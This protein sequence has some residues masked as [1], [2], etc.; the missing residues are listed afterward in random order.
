MSDAMSHYRIAD[1][2]LFRCDKSVLSH[3]KED[4]HQFLA[5]NEARL[6][7]FFCRNHG[8]IVSR[9]QIQNFVWKDNGFQVEDSNL[10]QAIFSLRKTLGDSS[11]K[12]KYI[13]TVPRKGYKFIASVDDVESENLAAEPALEPV[14][15]MTQK[16]KANYEG[17]FQLHYVVYALLIL[18]C[19]FLVSLAFN[20]SQN[21][22]LEF[23]PVAN[24]QGVEVKQ[25]NTSPFM[26]KWQEVTQACVSRHISTGSNS[27]NLSEVLIAVTQSKLAIHFVYDP[28]ESQKNFTLNLVS[29][30]QPSVNRCDNLELTR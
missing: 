23:E 26:E 7:E 14:N 2:Y 29:Y 10:T 13:L 11:K 30:G 3:I 15:A 25:I 8:R 18:F 28:L 19:I 5:N 16:R 20:Y 1:E 9:E 4:A 17:I 27:E 24:I 21:E 22:E 6:L 12:P